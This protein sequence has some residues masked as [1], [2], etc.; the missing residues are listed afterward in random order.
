M[1]V[2]LS[3]GFELGLEQKLTPQQVQYLKLLQLTGLQLEQHIS[4]ELEMNPMIEEGMSEEQEIAQETDLPNE[5][6]DYDDAA[7]DRSEASEL[8]ALDEYAPDRSDNPDEN[9]WQDYIEDEGNP[10]KY[11]ND[12]DHNGEPIPIRSES[13]FVEDLLEQISLLNFSEEEE[14]IAE[15]ILWSVESTGYLTRE[16]DEV[17]EAVNEKIIALNRQRSG[18]PSLILPPSH[19][20]ADA[21]NGSPNGSASGSPSGSPSSVGNGANN[22]SRNLS[23]N[24]SSNGSGNSA[25]AANGANNA[26]QPAKP[27]YDSRWLV[28]DGFDDDNETD[29]DYENTEDFTDNIEVSFGRKTSNR[30]ASGLAMK[31][32]SGASPAMTLAL[33]QDQHQVE[34]HVHNQASINDDGDGED[35][36][37]GDGDTL[38]ASTTKSAAALGYTP[39]RLVTVEQVEG[40]L[41]EV[42]TLD[43]P[44]I[45]ARDLREC[46]LSQLR[47]LPRLNAAQQLAQM[48][49]MKTYEAFTMRHYEVI[50]KELKVTDDYLREAIRAI[51][52]LNPK[53]GGGESGAGTS[54]IIPDFFIHYDD[55]KNDFIIQLNDSRVPNIR[56]N[57][58]YEQM[59]VQVREIAKKGVKSQKMN[60]DSKKF[61]KQKYDDAKFLIQALKQRRQT[62]IRVMT[63]IVHRQR[64]FFLRGKDFI[65]PLIYKN[66]AEDTGV[67]I[68][69]VC[70]VVNNKYTQTDYGIFELRY[71]F[72]EGIPKSVLKD[73][74]SG[75]VAQ[76][77]A[78]A[79]SPA[80][81]S[82]SGADGVEGIDGAL[83]ANADAGGDD[84]DGDG[85]GMDEVSTRIVKDKLR[86]LIGTEP[87]NKPL[88]DDKL[89]QELKNIG[90][91]IARRT[92]AK[93]RDQ[94]G[95][96]PARLRREL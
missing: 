33:S 90:Y 2:G 1:S 62:M 61:F 18:E 44:G 94:M 12:D 51:R 69:T 60:K 83:N 23:G 59:K 38:V 48:V 28:Y 66:I 37:E 93:Y 82:A 7:D 73:L 17:C 92:V 27:Y 41:L 26:A 45:A 76:G 8:T 56:V 91:T 20:A 87:K 96:A 84:G 81:G 29:A 6:D 10:S 32:H 71:F 72:S 24:S 14:I 85:D 49:L 86:D 43:P 50:M 67:D 75:K 34:S 68:S 57:K 74:E 3:I 19:Y 36:D 52:S 40:I 16:L 53:P 13:T 9:N 31:E 42:Q 64:E 30:P 77:A 15:E 11:A 25:Y 88:S 35:A 47:A 58:L 22:G 54:S 80:N 89:A 4:Q 95:I 46:L 55:E 63:A 5:S 78:N 70:R 39:L 79:N 21:V 65:R